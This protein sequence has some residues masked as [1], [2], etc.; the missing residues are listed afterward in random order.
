MS[1]ENKMFNDQCP[2]HHWRTEL[3]NI[4][5]DILKDPYHFR[6]YMHIKR[7]AGD[8]GG[9]IESREK[10]AEACGMSARKLDCSRLHFYNHKGFC[11]NKEQG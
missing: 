8:K 4:V 2:S 5:E 3:P 10:M 11:I 1:E 9:C 6:V 7:R